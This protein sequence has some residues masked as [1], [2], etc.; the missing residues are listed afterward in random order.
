MHW[1]LY[2][3]SKSK[4]MTVSM[5]GLDITKTYEHSGLRRQSL[6]FGYESINLIYL[7]TMFV[8]FSLSFVKI[9]NLKIMPKN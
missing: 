3:I 8:K 5:I 1:K 2:L 4:S 9:M 7:Y 6:I